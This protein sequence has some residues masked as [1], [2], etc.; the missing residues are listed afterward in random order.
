MQVRGTNLTAILR[1]F[2]TI[3][4]WY[5]NRDQVVRE[6]LFKDIRQYLYAVIYDNKRIPQFYNMSINYKEIFLTFSYEIVPL[7][8]DSLRCFQSVCVVLLSVSAVRK[9]GIGSA[10]K[11]PRSR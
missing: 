4:S 11:P 1:I 10:D 8:M 7:C 6:V 5:I 3:F 2:R 9:H